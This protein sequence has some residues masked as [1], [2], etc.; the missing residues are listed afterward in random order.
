MSKKTEADWLLWS[1][2][3]VERICLRVEYT[4]FGVQEYNLLP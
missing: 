4:L 3:P 1:T 2:A